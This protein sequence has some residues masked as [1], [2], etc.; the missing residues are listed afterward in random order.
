MEPQEREQLISRC[1]DEDLSPTEQRELEALMASDP[2]AGKLL[3]Q[4]RR[5][6]AALGD[7]GKV[8]PNVNWAE[9]NQRVQKA[10]DETDMQL[11]ARRRMPTWRWLVPL[12]AAAAVM[13]VAIPFWFKTTK[14]EPAQIV[15]STS[16]AVVVNVTVAKDPA[17]VAP[18][19]STDADDGGM[20]LCFT[21]KDK[22]QKNDSP[23]KPPPKG[24]KPSGFDDPVGMM[25]F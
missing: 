21:G 18:S 15:T 14:P 20:V 1:C 11:R 5:L 4:Y 24:T 25:F 6:D 8:A 17:E 12:S 19:D 16:P 13:L 2:Q 7:M 23:N 3:E 22:T 10:L 9:F